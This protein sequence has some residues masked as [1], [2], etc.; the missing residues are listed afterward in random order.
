MSQCSL[1]LSASFQLCHSASLCPYFSSPPA[2]DR[3]CTFQVFSR[4]VVGDGEQGVLSLVLIQPESYIC[5]GSLGEG[6]ALWSSSLSPW[7]PIYDFFI[8]EMLGFSSSS[9]SSFFLSF[10]ISRIPQLV[11]ILEDSLPLSLR[12]RIFLFFFPAA[13]LSLLCPGSRA[14]FYPSDTSGFCFI[15]RGLIRTSGFTPTDL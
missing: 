2:V 11:W 12:G 9:S 3:C 7:Q 14:F 15:E 10:S 5:S 8:L 13:T 6:C 1:A 4:L